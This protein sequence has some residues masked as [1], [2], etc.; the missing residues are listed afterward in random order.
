MPR[1]PGVGNL[2]HGYRG[3]LQVASA[4]GHS[5]LPAGNR[6]QDSEFE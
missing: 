6:N 1:K 2:P 5:M 3:F 4:P